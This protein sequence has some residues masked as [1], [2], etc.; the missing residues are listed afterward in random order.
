MHSA[1]VSEEHLRV[2]SVILAQVQTQESPPKCSSA[3]HGGGGGEQGGGVGG[4]AAASTG[5]AP[6]IPPAQIPVED[7]FGDIEMLDDSVLERFGDAAPPVAADGSA[8]EQWRI[9]CRTK[10][11]R[12]AEVMPEVLAKRA[13]QKH[14]GSDG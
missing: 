8:L 4:A 6:A 14:T 3:A 12:L 2:L 11:R 13:K 1:G 10:A 9:E 5:V 7:I